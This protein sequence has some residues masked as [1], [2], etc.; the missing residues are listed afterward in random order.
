MTTVMESNNLLKRWIDGTRGMPVGTRLWIKD[1]DFEL[2]ELAMSQVER[3]TYHDKKTIPVTAIFL[4]HYVDGR[5]IRNVEVRRKSEY[6]FL[7]IREQMDQ[8]VDQI[9]G[10]L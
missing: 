2:L 9:L 5:Y 8:A 3:Y 4:N 6:K 1:E 10:R 7:R